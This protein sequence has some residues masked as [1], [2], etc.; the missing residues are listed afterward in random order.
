M[1]LKTVA[2]MLAAVTGVLGASL[3]GA[4]AADTVRVRG[5]VAKL[6]GSTLTVKTREGKTDTVNLAPGWKLSGVS[7]ASV[8]DIKVG[9]FV[10]IASAPTA[11]GGAGALEVVIFPAAMK[12]TG[13]G[14]RPWDL[15]PNSRMTN[16]T[17]AS[18]VTGVNGPTLTLSYQNGQEKKISIPGGTPIV[19]LATAT[20][21]DLSP[22]A[23]VVV[24][25][26][27]GTD[28]KLTSNRVVVGNHGVAPPM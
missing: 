15:K 13:E 7:K 10:G 5:T 17:V 18:Q 1:K 9:D 14:D 20:P 6:D 11:N 8:N 23:A 24:T 21:A 28:G 16:G 19:T 3:V 25:A 22:G 26:E 2:M 27:R 12:G 4:T